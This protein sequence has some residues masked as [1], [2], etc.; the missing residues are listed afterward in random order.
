M[1]LAREKRTLPPI[2]LCYS[3]HRCRK[4][5]PPVLPRNERDS[6]GLHDARGVTIDAFGAAMVCQYAGCRLL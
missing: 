2:L 6:W 5:G 3:L 1:S 4:A